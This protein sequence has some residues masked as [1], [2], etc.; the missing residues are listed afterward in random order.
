[1]LCAM[2]GLIVSGPPGS[3]KTTLARALAAE[4]DR[5]VHL[6]T[7]QFFAAITRGFVKPW[8]AEAAAQNGVV[9]NA[10]AAAAV[11]YMAA[12]YFVL[13]DGVVL[14]WALAIY[15]ERAAEAGLDVGIAVL[16]PGEDETARRGLSRPEDYGLTAEVYR[17][18]HGQF[19]KA[20]F[21]AGEII[22]STGMSVAELVVE[23]RRRGLVVGAA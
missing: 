2:N 1:M 17:E 18:M 9:V 8:L 16:L 14:P 11:E 7:D 3:G 15:R 5:S 12:G 6:Q 19:V 23:V 10:I 13:V 21:A 4:V 20:G 22:D